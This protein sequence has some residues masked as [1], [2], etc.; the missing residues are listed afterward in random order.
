VVQDHLIEHFADENS[1][2]DLASLVAM[3]P[4]NLSRVFK[5]KTG[6]TIHEYLTLLRLEFAKTMLNNPDFTIE[7]IATKCGFKTPRQLQRL[8]KANKKSQQFA[9]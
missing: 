5:E 8:L 3:S 7:Y 1:I 6:T 4:R 9:S 2:E